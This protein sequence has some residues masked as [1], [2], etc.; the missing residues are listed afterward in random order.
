V[1]IGWL[2]QVAWRIARGGS[3]V[4]E[5]TATNPVTILFLTMARLIRRTILLVC[6][7][8]C[9][10]R[11]QLCALGRFLWDKVLRKARFVVA[12]CF[13]V[14]CGLT[15]RVI[16]RTFTGLITPLFLATARLIRRAILLVRSLSRWTRV[17][18]SGFGRFLWEN[19]FGKARFVVGV[20]FE[21][22]CGLTLG[23]MLGTF[24]SLNSAS[25]LLHPETLVFV[26]GA[27]GAFLGFLI[28]IARSGPADEVILD[29][30]PNRL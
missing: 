27:L 7:L 1:L 17:Q 8:S 24:A 20:C 13:E 19:V 14:V 29:Q 2:V 10:T 28:G 18:L 3:Q 12:V 21:I 6:S 26:G 25:P 9:W 15:L 22:V 16:L 11:V 5:E 30:A 23:V 4:G